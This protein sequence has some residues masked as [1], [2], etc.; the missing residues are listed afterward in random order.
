[1]SLLQKVLKC[2]KLDDLLRK[3]H[4]EARRPKI[5]PWG[6]PY[7]MGRSKRQSAKETMKKCEVKKETKKV[8]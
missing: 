3:K 7:F 2:M 8:Q 5:V 4:R 6:T 1:M